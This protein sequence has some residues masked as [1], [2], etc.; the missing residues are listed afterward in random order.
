LENLYLDLL[1]LY[2]FGM[3]EICF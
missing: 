2:F 3:V 1:Y